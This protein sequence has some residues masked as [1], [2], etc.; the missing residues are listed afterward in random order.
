MTSRQ[1]TIE[2]PPLHPG[3]KRVARSKAR[4]NVLASGRRWGKTRLGSIMGVAEGLRKGRVFWIAPTYKLTAPGWRMIQ[5]LSAPIPGVEIHKAD[6]LIT[7]PGGG[8]V[9]VRSAD[10][11]NSLRGDGL[12]LAILDE[13]AFMLEEAWTEALRPAL[14]DRKGHAWFISTPKRRNWFHRLYTQA[15]S[16]PG[17]WAAWQLPTADNPFIDPTEIEAARSSIPEDVFRQEYLA[18]F[19]EGSGSVFRNITACLNAPLDATPEQHAGHRIIAGVDWGQAHDFT[20]VS[21]GC[22]DCRQEVERHRSNQTEYA[23][24]VARIGEL[25]R[26][27]GIESILVETNAM[28]QPIFEQLQREGLPVQGFETTAVSKP[29]LIENL[30]LTLER[31]EWQFM[32]DPIW[33]AELEAYERRVNNITGRSSYSAPEGIHDDTV[34]GRAL[35]LR[36]ITGWWYT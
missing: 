15:Q 31:A 2:F 8:E 3:Q 10:D 17:E 1:I 11:P 19:L 23:L 5:R 25:Y 4:F 24:Q 32:D 16:D 34:M 9:H 21:V 28:G 33:T 29:P 13:C 35:M 14:S 36:T 27:W 26:K 7:Y 22:A 18:E 12:S 6:K 30:A 20:A